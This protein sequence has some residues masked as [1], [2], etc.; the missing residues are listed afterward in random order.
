[1]ANMMYKQVDMLLPRE[2]RLVQSR[3]MGKNIEKC[4]TR[5]EVMGSDNI[6]RSRYVTI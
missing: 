4:R 5:L 6:K 1:M 3:Q 2:K